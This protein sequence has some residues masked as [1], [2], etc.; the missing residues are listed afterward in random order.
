MLFKAYAK[1]NLYLDV[2]NKRS[3]GYHD[4]LTLFQTIPIY[5]EIEIEFSEKEEFHSEP[6]LN[7]PWEK[8]IIK[9]AIDTF[10]KL[11][12]YKFNLK[13]Q[14]QKKLPQGGGIGGGSADA[15]AVL[16]FLKE[17][18][19]ISDKD[20]IEIG[21]KIGGDVPFLIFGG[22]AIAEGIGDKLTFLNPLNLN[23]EFNFPGIH[24]STPE[25]YG[26]IDNNWNELQRYGDPYKLY[27]ALK[28]KNFMLAR[29]NAFNIFEQVV[30]KKYPELKKIKYDM[31]KKSVFS[32]MSGSGSTIFAI[33]KAQP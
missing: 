30:F 15:A 29:E 12:G 9:K 11:T 28:E 2:V 1:V 21:T 27:E 4:I 19:N 33:N 16:K 3:D 20:I 26:E 18:Y 10:K 5:D 32:L 6:E 24:V 17:H 23:F 13:I 25:M 7:F 8:N 22:T 31:S 14:L